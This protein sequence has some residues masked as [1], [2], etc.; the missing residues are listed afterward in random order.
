LV[1]A[2]ASWIRVSEAG[3]RHVVTHIPVM[4]Y[5]ARLLRRGLPGAPPDA[6]VTFASPACQALFGKSPQDMLGDYD[7]WLKQVHVND[8]EL[9]VAALNQLFL[10]NRPVTCEYRLTIPATPAAGKPDKGD[11]NSK[12]GSSRAP[13]DASLAPLLNS[14]QP[15]PAGGSERWVRD[16]MSPNYHA[17]GELLGWDGVVEDITE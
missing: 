12:A 11:R 5:S 17:D 8:R 4:L 14:L 16:T 13:A 10:Q 2:A 7:G 3:Y 6:E 15:T 9:M 1:G